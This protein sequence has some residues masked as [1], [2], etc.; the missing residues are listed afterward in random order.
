MF[1]PPNPKQKALAKI[2]SHPLRTTIEACRWDWFCSIVCSPGAKW[3]G[4]YYRV[5][6][7]REVWSMG[8]CSPLLS[9]LVSRGIFFLSLHQDDNACSKFSL[10][11][12]H[13]RIWC[14]FLSFLSNW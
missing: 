8:A 13:L 10:V 5:L 6:F 12:I 7:L 3:Y 11:T 9:P 14:T 2:K 1:G 4:Y